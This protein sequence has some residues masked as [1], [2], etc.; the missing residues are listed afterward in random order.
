MRIRKVPE[1]A[2]NPR[3]DQKVYQEIISWKCP[4]SS[5]ENGKSDPGSSKDPK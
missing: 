4:K 1:G 3:K 5:K 2:Q